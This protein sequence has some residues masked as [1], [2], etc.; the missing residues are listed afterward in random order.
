MLGLVGDRRSIS[1]GLLDQS[2]GRLV[3]A[4]VMQRERPL[5]FVGQSRVVT[6]PRRFAVAILLTS[7]DRPPVRADSSG[8]AT[9]IHNQGAIHSAR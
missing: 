6:Q 7:H 8:S 2:I 3:L 4:L 1:L 5:F 9:L